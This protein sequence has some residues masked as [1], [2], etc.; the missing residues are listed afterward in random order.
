MRRRRRGTTAN[1][2]SLE[3][4]RA[5]FLSGSGLPTLGFVR[6]VRASPLVEFLSVLVRTRG[7]LDWYAGYSSCV[8][9]ERR[10]GA[11]RMKAARVAAGERATTAREA[12]GEKA[13]AAREAAGERATA[14]REAAKE[15]ATAAKEATAE[16]IAAVKPRLRGRSHE[17]AF[18]LSIGLGIALVSA[19]EYG[20][21]PRFRNDLRA[22]PLGAA[23]HERPL[24]PR[25]L[26]AAAGPRLD[27]APRPHDDL[28]PD[29]GDLHALRGPAARR[30]AGRRDPRRRSG[31]AP[32]RARSSR[33]SGSR[34][35]SGSGR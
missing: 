12:M 32:L 13:V 6:S 8:T 7:A 18:F 33:C 28:L 22:Q 14:A 31:P 27:A 2:P 23:R 3:S 9:D 21:R 24:P 15:T 29:R 26:E 5:P 25:Q 19:A 10:T 11:E 4:H 1:R 16:A 20:R 35:R 30:A 34:T 17:W